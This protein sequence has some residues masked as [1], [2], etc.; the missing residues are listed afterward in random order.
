ML[1]DISIKCDKFPD[2]LTYHYQRWIPETLKG[3]VVFVHGLGDHIGRYRELISALSQAGF[4]CAFYDQRGHGQSRGR[5]GHANHF[6]DWVDDLAYFI[7]AST[8]A[9]PPETPIYLIGA[10]LGALVGIN[11]IL[12]HHGPV[13]GFIGLSSAIRPIIRIPQWKLNLG[14]KLA[15]VL[16]WVSIDNAIE[17]DHLTRDDREIMKL[18]ADKYFHRSITL[19]AGVE[20]ERRLDLIMAVPHRIHVP[21]LMLAGSADLICDPRGTVEFSARLASSDKRS[22]VYEGMHHDLLHDIGKERVLGDIVGWL[23][24][25]ATGAVVRNQD[26]SNKGDGDLS[27]RRRGWED[28]FQPVR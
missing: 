16:P 24:E 22:V 13:S 4:G 11:Y 3:L 18:A 23:S 6:A 27:R 20:I 15:C 14:R 9:V 12:I 10:S 2:G 19:G 25:R 28:M 21:A 1:M 26:S 17:M 5:R 7:G 8:E